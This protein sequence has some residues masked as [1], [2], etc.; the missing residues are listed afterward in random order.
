[1]L[2]QGPTLRLKTG[3]D[4]LDPIPAADFSGLCP[5]LPCFFVRIL[6]PPPPLAAD[7]LHPL[8]A[9]PF[10]LTPFVMYTRLSPPSGPTQRGRLPVPHLGF[11]V[12]PVFGPQ[13]RGGPDPSLHRRGAGEP[14]AVVGEPSGVD[15]DRLRQ[16][17]AD[18]EGL[19]SE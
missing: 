13:G 14:A 18:L 19:I 10:P 6:A 7:P 2:H 9:T 3:K 4:L 11:V 8:S 1:M 17:D 12:R 15:R 5:R 16:Q